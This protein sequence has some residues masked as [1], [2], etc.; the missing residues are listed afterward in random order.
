MGFWRQTRT[1]RHQL[2]RMGRLPTRIC[3]QIMKPLNILEPEYSCGSYTLHR[4]IQCICQRIELSRCA[5]T[6]TL[7]FLKCTGRA[8]AQHFVVTFPSGVKLVSYQPSQRVVHSQTGACYVSEG[9]RRV[10][11]SDSLGVI[12]RLYFMFV[13]GWAHAVCC[14]LRTR[15]RAIGEGLCRG[16]NLHKWRKPVTLDFVIQDERLICEMTESLPA[17]YPVP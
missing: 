15:K 16:N 2:F 12:L 1:Y 14:V 9:G 10:I 6:I 11:P 5:N 13:F 8:N 4:N 7:P 3:M 17:C